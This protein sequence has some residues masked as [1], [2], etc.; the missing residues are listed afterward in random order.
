MP[1][2][3]PTERSFRKPGSLELDPS[4]E[5]VPIDETRRLI[6]SNK[7]EGTAVYDPS[8][9]HLGVVHNFMVDKVSGQVAYAV[10]AFGGFLGL[11]ESHYPLPWR[12]LSYSVDLGGYV[13]DLDRDTLAGAP[14]HGPGEDAFADPAYGGRLDDYYGGRLAPTA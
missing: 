5:G 1:T 8:G 7:V 4:A 11:G 6:A 14:S 12:A 9:E 10:L 3:L 2:D 13:V